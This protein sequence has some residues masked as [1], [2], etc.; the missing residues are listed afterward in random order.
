MSSS[1]VQWECTW[2]R[3]T[4]TLNCGVVWSIR[5]TGFKVLEN[6]SAV[7]FLILHLSHSAQPLNNGLTRLFFIS[8]MKVVFVVDRH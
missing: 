5:N 4:F 8:Y 3:C 7:W 1:G 6:G 2:P